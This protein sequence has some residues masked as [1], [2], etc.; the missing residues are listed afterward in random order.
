VDW[1]KSFLAQNGSRER[2]RFLF[3]EREFRR[4][5]AINF[6]SGSGTG[7]PMR[8][9]A[10]LTDLMTWPQLGFIYN[11]SELNLRWSA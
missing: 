6:G 11:P 3:L 5:R 1:L 2:E 4:P 9:F 7:R 8:A 10:I